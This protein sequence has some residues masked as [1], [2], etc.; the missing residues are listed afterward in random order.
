LLEAMTLLI[1]MPSFPTA[2]LW[3]AFGMSFQRSSVSRMPGKSCHSAL[4]LCLGV[5]H[6]KFGLRHQCDL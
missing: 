1:S 5:E 2:L 4:G 6:S 3:L